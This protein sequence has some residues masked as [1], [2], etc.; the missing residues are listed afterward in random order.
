M[1]ATFAPPKEGRIPFS[2]RLGSD[3][4]FGWMR[5]FRCPASSE[6]VMAIAETNAVAEGLHA[7]M[8]SARCRK[9]GEAAQVWPDSAKK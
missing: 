8:A 5:V 9:P 6:A 3:T 2:M 7:R 1:T 4:F